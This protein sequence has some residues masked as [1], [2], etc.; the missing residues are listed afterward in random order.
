MQ[1]QNQKNQNQKNQR[2]QKNQN[3]QNNQNCLTFMQSNKTN[4]K[5]QNKE[6]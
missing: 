3:N 5:I 2:N 6:G 4:H 1:N